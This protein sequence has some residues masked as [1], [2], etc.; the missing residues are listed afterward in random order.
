MQAHVEALRADEALRRGQRLADGLPLPGVALHASQASPPGSRVAD[1]LE[2]AA[3]PVAAAA[4]DAA[5][6]VDEERDRRHVRADRQRAA[7]RQQDAA[8]HARRARRRTLSTGTTSG[9]DEIRIAAA[10]GVTSSDSTSSAPTICTD[11]ATASPS[12]TM[13][14][15]DDEPDRHAARGGDVGVEAVEGQRPPDHQQRRSSTIAPMSDERAELRV[16]DRDDL[17]GQQ[18][19]LVGAAARDT[20]RG[21]GCR[22]RARTAS[23]RR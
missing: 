4:D 22:A 15:S 23:A 7:E 1:E 10:A 14:A 16:V 20:A 9:D 3:A 6:H 12:S 21:T 13:K 2:A 18:P 17:P 19:E 8:D 11:T 5:D